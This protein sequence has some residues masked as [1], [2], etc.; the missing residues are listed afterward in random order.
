MALKTVILVVE[1]EAIIRMGAVQMLED[2]GFTVVEAGNAH[3]ALSILEGR[4]DVCA[5]FTD[6]N[7]PGTMDGMRLARMVRG[8][9]P[10]IHVIV[11]SGLVFPNNDDLPPGGKFIHKPYDPRHVIA[12]LRQ[13]LGQ[14]S[15]SD[16]RLQARKAA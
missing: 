6:I 3:D 2:A 8:R 11:T 5:I 15:P 14:T 4:K 16:P 1:D 9:W 13:L 7:M 10:P 12:T